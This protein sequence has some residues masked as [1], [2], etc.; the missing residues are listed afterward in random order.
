MTRALTGGD[1]SK[2]NKGDAM[3]QV[4][5]LS[6]GK[7]QRHMSPIK[8]TTIPEP[9]RPPQTTKKLRKSAVF[10]SHRATY[11]EVQSSQEINLRALRRQRNEYREKKKKVRF[12]HNGGKE[13]VSVGE[14]GIS[15]TKGV[16][17]NKKGRSAK[18]QRE[19]E[20]VMTNK[21]ID[22]QVEGQPVGKGCRHDGRDGAR[23][24]EGDGV[25][26]AGTPS[27]AKKWVGSKELAIDNQTGENKNG[28]IDDRGRPDI[29][30]T[31]CEQAP[32]I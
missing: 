10:P 9:H 1:G 13:A 25:S 28:R 11:Q 24:T 20:N 4:R 23:D 32:S 19:C 21:L 8:P 15:C 5:Q 6:K 17:R 22:R 31:S 16:M 3:S 14:V 2:V 27:S 26:F 12:S 7:S 29:Q 30:I 18:H